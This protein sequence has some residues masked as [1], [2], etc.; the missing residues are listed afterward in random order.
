MRLPATISSIFSTHSAVGAAPASQ[1][2]AADQAPAPSTMGA[3]QDSV[4][5]F[6]KVLGGR[7]EVLRNRCE[8]FLTLSQ[9]VQPLT[10]H[11]A[12]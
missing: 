12:A 8:N 9:A 3:V 10:A 11:E 4:G 1:P 5:S 6:L 7:N 2:C